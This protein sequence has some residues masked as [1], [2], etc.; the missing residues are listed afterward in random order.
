MDK[1][2]Y[3]KWPGFILVIP[4][5]VVKTMVGTWGGGTNGLRLIAGQLT[6]KR[7]QEKQNGKLSGRRKPNSSCKCKS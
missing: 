6:E 2:S 1:S 4:I 3:V 5:G 7:L